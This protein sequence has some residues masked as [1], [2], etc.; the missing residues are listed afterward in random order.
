L[1][2]GSF[3]T[4]SRLSLFFHGSDIYDSA[5]EIDFEFG[6]TGGLQPSSCLL[7]LSMVSVSICSLYI[8]VIKYGSQFPQ[9]LNVIIQLHGSDPVGA[10]NEFWG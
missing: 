1:P 10:E 5:P 8:E 7:E 2:N 4:R 9:R 3:E 6:S